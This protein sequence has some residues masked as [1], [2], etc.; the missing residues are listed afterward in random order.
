M[1]ESSRTRI[2][3]PASQVHSGDGDQYNFSL[4][5]LLDPSA[6]ARRRP[7]RAIAPDELLRLERR[8]VAPGGLG[9][10]RAVLSE[11][12]TVLLVGKPGTGRYS[13]AAKL[14]WELRR[15]HGRMQ[16]LDDKSE[17]HDE[18]PLD[19]EQVEAEDRLL[20]DLTETEEESSRRLLEDLPSFRATVLDRRAFLAVALSSEHR[21]L[22]P[23]Q[24]DTFTVP[25]D[26]PDPLQVF[27]KHLL[28]VQIEP[29]E[30]E[31]RNTLLTEHLR[32]ATPAAIAAL[33]TEVF[34]ERERGSSAIFAKW[35]DRALEALAPK[36]PQVTST[37]NKLPDRRELALLLTAALLHRARADVVNNAAERMLAAL[38]HPPDEEPLL[39]RTALTQ[40]LQACGVDVGPDGRVTFAPGYAP[41]VRDYFWDNYPELREKLPAWVGETVSIH[42]LDSAD[43]YAFVDRYAEQCLRIGTPGHLITL[44][45]GWSGSWRKRQ[46]MSVAA[47]ALSRGVADKRHGGH[48]RRRIYDWSTTPGLAPPLAHL[49]VGACAQVMAVDHPDQALTRLLHLAR[50]QGGVV[51]EDA[52]KELLRLA[53][54]DD[55]LHRRLLSKLTH[56][57]H[58]PGAADSRV[59][60][61]LCASSR[62]V[63]PSGHSLGLLADAGVRRGLV[64]GWCEALQRLPEE[65]WS[66]P[67]DLWLTQA[68]RETP[69]GESL[70]N[71]LVDS[72][73]RY[74]PTLGRLYPY[75]RDWSS[76][77]PGGHGLADRFWA[78][79]AVSL[80]ITPLTST[81]E[82]PS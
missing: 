28:A 69:V 70:L 60:L 8:F 20:L 10:A 36:S 61:G 78:R 32:R 42:L 41:A 56:G 45:E 73:A 31:L 50:R 47:R 19:P 71:V 3:T 53:G 14:L 12:R 40:R 46:R 6:F 30:A 27:R 37:I 63:G 1:S 34:R 48:F 68:A 26:R 22:V 79:C 59:F 66:E 17:D 72:C 44:I 4:T 49:L 76:V 18:R 15:D 9:R 75:V 23:P 2:D 64:T 29:A 77:T 11:S 57:S 62:T 55:R 43:Q 67:L 24:L 21:H 39:H 51:A 58:T 16:Q 52:R 74:G 80:G 33:A 7:S 54:R 38:D 25:L 35:R 5:T 81:K 65:E 13:A 82:E